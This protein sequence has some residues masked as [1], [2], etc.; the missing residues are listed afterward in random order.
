MSNINDFINNTIFANISSKSIFLY[1]II[2][3]SCL[4]YFKHIHISLNYIIGICVSVIII[5]VLYKYEIETYQNT[6]KLHEI[7]KGY[8]FP[9]SDKI[10]QYKEITDIVFSIQ[11]F[12]EY[13]P[14]AFESMINSLETF[15]NIYENI[16]DDNSLSGDLYKNADNYK[17][18]VLNH[19]HSII[20]MIPSDKNLIEKLN[21]SMKNMEEILNDYLTKIYDIHKN[22]VDKNGYYNNTK[23]IELNI[24]PYNHYDSN[25]ITQYY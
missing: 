2:V 8:I 4:L 11:D 17:L 3:V 21:N 16:S 18:L 9:P 23:L 20:I 6:E 22:Y 5:A 15:L 25:T 13:N 12:Y 1:T 19:L 24:Y 14:Q 10:S 7:K